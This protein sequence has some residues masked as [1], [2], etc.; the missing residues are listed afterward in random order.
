MRHLITVFSL[1]FLVSCSN[2]NR[3]VKKG[4]LEEKYDMAVAKY[5]KKDYTRALP[6]FEDL[7]SIYRGRE[8]AEEI[9]YYYAYCFYG[10][11]QFE[12]A[13]F[14]F[15]TFTESFYNSVHSEEC[16]YMYVHCLFKDALPY[17]LDPTTTEK[18]IEEMQLFLNEY[19]DTKYRVVC[20]EQIAELRAKLLKKSF[21]NAMLFYNIEDYRAAI[22]SF[23]NTL[24]DFPEVDN[25]DEIEYLIVKSAYLYAKLSI[26]EKKEERYK[27]VFEEFNEFASNNKPSNQYYKSALEINNRA[28]KDLEKHLQ[29]NSKIS[30]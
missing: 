2:Y 26:E 15:K 24:K 8:K 20:N 9:Y 16:N 12:L 4:T 1:F 13:A 17:Y 23:K 21:K 30:S 7:L 25:K 18:A 5:K 28:K 10:M 3:V 22:I 11:G 14:H 29:K 6:L 27:A 19:E